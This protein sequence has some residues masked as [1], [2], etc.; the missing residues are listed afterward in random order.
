MSVPNIHAS[1]LGTSGLPYLVKSTLGGTTGDVFLI[2]SLVAITV[3]ALAVHTGGI[4]MIFTMGRDGR[5]PF[6]S[7]IARV[8]GKS[9]TPLVPSIVIGVVTI[10]LLVLNVG[11]QKA[12]FVLTSVAIIMFYIAYLCVTGPLLVA[13]LRGTWPT[14]SHGPYFSLGRW[15]L[16]VNL[17][18]V[19]FQVGVMVNL[20][21][22]RPAV[23][24]N[25]A[26]Y[27]Q[28]GAFVFVGFFAVV[29]GIYYF[30]VQRGRT[31]TVLAEHRAG[32]ELAA[33]GVSDE[34][35]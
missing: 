25:S 6:A 35:A 13:R 2:D 8:H 14:P 29:G 20:A 28:W 12:F 21:W 34:T 10:L 5:L 1:Q 33:A 4:R 22:P 26:W 7:S 18:A 23:Y 27:Y 30:V 19:I 17:L 11:N 32:P 9:K 15:G 3:C 24:G 16:P 31:D